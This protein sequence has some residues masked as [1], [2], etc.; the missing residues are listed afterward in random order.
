MTDNLGKYSGA[1]VAS[2]NADGT[3][4]Y[5]LSDV[6]R[7]VA[8]DLITQGGDPVGILMYVGGAIGVVLSG[9]IGSKYIF[10]KTPVVKPGVEENKE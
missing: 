2:R 1:P 8:T 3:P 7:E 9:W 4:N 6:A 5:A 10:K